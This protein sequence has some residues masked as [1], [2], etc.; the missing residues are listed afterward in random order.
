MKHTGIISGCVTCHTGQTYNSGVLVKGKDATGAS[1]FPIP[2]TNTCE[3]CHSISNFT[4]F[5]GT[6]MS[7]TL[8]S[9]GCAS[10]HTDQTYNGGI[11]VKGMGTTAPAHLPTTASPACETCHS[12]SNFSTFSGT[13]MKH[14][15]IVSGC[16]TCH[17]GQAFQ[18]VTPK[19]KGTSP[20]HVPTTASPACETCHSISNFT[21]FSGTGMV[22]TGITT[23]CAS[24]HTSQ[25]FQGVSPVSKLSNHLP[26]TLVCETCHLPVNFST[27]NGTV[28]VHTGIT[29]GCATCH[30]NTTY[31]NGMT[32]K[33]KPSNHIV[34]SGNL[35]GG[36]TMACEFCHSTT[37]FTAFTA[38]KSST[39]IH[40]GTQGNGSGWCKNCHA[41]GVTANLGVQGTK[42]L[43]HNP[44]TGVTA[45]DC[46]QSSCHKPLGSKG[47]A[48]V[49]FD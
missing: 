44:I 32:P 20:V 40:N 15:L 33:Y 45:T 7:H 49:N 22:H 13:T 5:S 14:T 29:S 26:T 37:S 18:G 27:F 28:M 9:S 8:I 48:Y 46:S 1:H 30:S 12:I 23:G 36:S 43:T 25:V 19:T 10:C 24:C 38:L 11:K 6:N 31:Q 34:Y 2:S 35:T 42:S 41:T 4:T 17:G 39:I 21:T 16:A 47:T 3:S